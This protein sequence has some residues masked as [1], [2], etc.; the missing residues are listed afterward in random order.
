VTAKTLVFIHGSDPKQADTPWMF[1]HLHP[2]RY[3]TPALSEGETFKLVY[4]DFEKGERKEW[5]AWTATRSKK[6]PTAGPDTTVQLAPRVKIRDQSGT[7]YNPEFEAP[8]VLA[9]YDWVKAQPAKSIVAIEIFSH[10]VTYQPVLFAPSYEWGDDPVKHT[11]PT[12]ERDPNDTEF[13]L[14]DFEGKNPLSGANTASDPWAVS[15]ELG[16]FRAA[17]SDDAFI[18]IW[19]CGEQTLEG[20]GGPIRKKLV[21]FLALKDE[22]KNELRRAVLLDNYLDEVETYFAFVLARALN[23]PVWAGPV[24]WGSDP[25]EVDGNYD[26]KTYAANHYT[27]KGKFP[28][29]LKKKELWWRVSINFTF[30]KRLVDF[31]KTTL[32]ANVDPMGYVEYKP[33]WFRAARDATQK[34]LN[35]PTTPSRF[36]EILNAPSKLVNQLLD[37]IG[38][39]SGS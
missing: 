13:R 27:W 19:G 39:S 30:N 18:K 1:Y 9:F 3:S 21:D 17:I 32:R 7:P 11:N 8:S 37:R 20:H 34:V 31:F 23:L 36:D 29:N 28:P 38:G 2:S 4:F 10:G 16:K 25:Y 33:S 6:S 26:P 14:R 22:K 12:A 15:S 24:G 5:N 35:P